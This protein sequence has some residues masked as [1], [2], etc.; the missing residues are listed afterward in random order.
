MGVD[1][2]ET[3][4][5]FPFT[6][7]N[8]LLEGVTPPDG[9]TPIMMQIGEPQAAVPDSVMRDIAA[10][11]DLFGRYP[12]PPG[13]VDYRRAVADWAVG[14]YGLKP[15]SLDPETQV[16]ATSGSREA[17][18][19]AALVAA[20]RKQVQLPDGVRLAILVPN[21]LYHVYAGGAI[22]ADC[23]LI[24]VSTT[25]DNDFTP[26]YAGLPDEI[27]ARTAL[28]FLCTPGNPTGT[29]A[30]VEAIS[31]MLTLARRHDFTLAVDECYSE[32]WMDK[33]PTG[34]L[35]AAVALDGP[36]SDFS[37]L[38]TFNSLSKRSGVPGLRCGFI[39]GAAQ[40]IGQIARVR[41]YGGAT[42]PGPLMAAGAALW[43]EESHVAQNR[44]H[45]AQLI[46]IAD[47][48]LGHLPGYRRPEAAFFLWLDVQ[49]TAGDG[50]TAAKRLWA[51]QGVK[52]LPGRYMARP[53]SWDSAQADAATPGD[54]Y[55]RIAL[56][57]DPDTVAEACA[58]I[59]ACL[60]G[61]A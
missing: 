48:A 41:S 5:D 2:L 1:K 7:L 17:L 24:P 59:A 61:R 44:A 28:C 23:D 33:A 40:M 18:F 16:L 45:Y 12:P 43:R 42:L 32:I 51:E 35:E 4:G 25:P 50:V 29:V 27:L 34:G 55:V 3:L 37:H 6:R 38:L 10:H 14:R 49:Q 21:P 60:G 30:S 56:V 57:H 39:A 13:S 36:D 22:M 53:E 19:Q 47:R 8:R 9:M 26:D 11:A 52:V 58:R 20:A 54:G 15:G 46:E 31:Q